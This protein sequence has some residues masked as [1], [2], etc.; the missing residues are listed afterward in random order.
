MQHLQQYPL[1]SHAYLS[2]CQQHRAAA[3]EMQL[4]RARDEV[5]KASQ[6]GLNAMRDVATGRLE[7]SEALNLMYSVHGDPWVPVTTCC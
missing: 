5:R 2:Y 3:A 4:A 7:I 6:R 1:A